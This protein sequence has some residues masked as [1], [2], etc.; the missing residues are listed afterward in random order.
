MQVASVTVYDTQIFAGF[1][2][3]KGRVTKGS[4]AVGS[5]VNSL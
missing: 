1:V 2:L 4:V 5:Q 3:H